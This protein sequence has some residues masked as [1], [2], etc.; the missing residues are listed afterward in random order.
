MNNKD[1]KT[2][3]EQPITSAITIDFHK[4]LK[5][6]DEISDSSEYKQMP[7]N[8]KQS[9][10]WLG[11]YLHEHQVNRCPRIVISVTNVDG[12]YYA[13][14]YAMMKAGSFT[15]Q[16]VDVKQK[17]LAMEQD[18]LDDVTIVHIHDD[19]TQH[20]LKF[21]ENGNLNSPCHYS[22]PLVEMNNRFYKVWYEKRRKK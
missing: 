16:D 13:F 18:R 14:R 8:V 4:T 3:F 2:F 15:H 1:I 6:Y 19:H 5:P 22:S 20:E 12:T 11:I 21:D 7:D 17:A 9:T 10:R